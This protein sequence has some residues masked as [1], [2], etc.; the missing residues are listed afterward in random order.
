M[1]VK[2]GC[3]Y[4]WSELPTKAEAMDG[5]AGSGLFCEAGK[6]G[7]EERFGRTCGVSF[8]MV[9]RAIRPACN[10]GV[11]VRTGFVNESL[12]QPQRKESRCGEFQLVQASCKQF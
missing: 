1:S 9:A 6:S 2:E 10:G 5:G 8:S 12:L 3:V 7:L 11:F 4:G